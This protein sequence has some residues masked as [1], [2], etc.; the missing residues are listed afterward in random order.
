LRFEWDRL[1]AAAN[2]RKH[3]VPFA[4]ATSVFADPLAAI[5]DDSAHSLDETREIIVGHSAGRRLLLV[6]FVERIPGLIRIISARKIT[7]MEKKDYEEDNQ[8]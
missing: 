7:G 1:K 8:R 2:L 3:R 5:F 4:E 6:V